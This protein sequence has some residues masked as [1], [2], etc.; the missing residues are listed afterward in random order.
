MVKRTG[1]DM[2][3]VMSQHKLSSVSFCMIFVIVIVLCMVHHSKQETWIKPQS[4]GIKWAPPNGDSKREWYKKYAIAAD[5]EICGKVGKSILQQNGSVV[6]AGIATLFCTGV[7]D[8][9]HMG[10]GG[11]N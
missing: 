7:V 10:V 5:S 11:G 2:L 4:K 3:L 9:P 8:Q 6:D 1:K